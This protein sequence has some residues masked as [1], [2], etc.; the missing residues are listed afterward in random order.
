MALEETNEQYRQRVRAGFERV[1]ESYLSAALDGATPEQQAIAHEELERAVKL[2]EAQLVQK[3]ENF[4]KRQA[5]ANR[6][7]LGVKVSEIP[8]TIG[9]AAMILFFGGTLAAAGYGL[10]SL[11]KPHPQESVTAQ[12]QYSARPRGNTAKIGPATLAMDAFGCVR[13][14]DLSRIVSLY[15]DGDNDAATRFLASRVMSKTC[16]LFDKGEHVYV[17]GHMP[18]A[19][20]SKI[21]KEGDHIVYL[22]GMYSFQ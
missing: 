13:A 15:G 3:K 5:A 14:E 20:Y 9:L 19:G 2:H 18:L 8:A 4:Q 11:F 16:T 17:E 12:A 1:R 21:R 10:Y 7:F 6:K 22:V